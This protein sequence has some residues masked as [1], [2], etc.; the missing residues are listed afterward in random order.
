MSRLED[1][2]PM[3]LPAGFAITPMR[4][5]ELAV[6]GD[7]AAAEGWNPG[8][9]DLR[10]A[11]QTD[12]QAFVTLREGDRL[13]G[14]GSIYSY[15]GRF[16]FMGLFIMRADLRR[17]GLG[18]VLWH[19][20]RDT[21]LG[22]LREGASIGMDGVFDMVP[23]YEKGGFKPAYRDLRYQGIAAGRRSGRVITLGPADFGDIE[24]YDRAFFPAPRAAF[25][26]GWLSQ[27]G[28]HIAGIRE[29]GRLVACGVARPCRVGFK[30]GPLFADRSDVAAD[31]LG[32][33]MARIAGSQVQID[34]PEPNEAGLAIARGLGLSM[35]FG[36]VRLYHGP[37]PALPVDRIFG[38]TSLEFG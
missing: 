2:H 8:L 29:S 21:L 3:Q 36:C 25:L 31:V 10:I 37:D 13:A 33:L 34:I 11:W 1:E 27:G 16:G 5:N 26:R 17:Q 23:F 30:I 12:S 35:S 38:V 6:L 9:S 4:E 7:W 20:R 14:G 18:A 19:W 32:D 24:A 22:R 28:A 15:D